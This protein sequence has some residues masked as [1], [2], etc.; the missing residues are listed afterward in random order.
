[1][2]DVC[3]LCKEGGNLVECDE[4]TSWSRRAA[5]KPTRCKKVYHA[6][7]M[8]F[9]V[10]DDELSSC[11]RHACVECGEAAGYFCRCV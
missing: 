2:E 7:C 1:T 4:G 10:G 6:Y 11:P 9:N 8:G 5:A 3:F